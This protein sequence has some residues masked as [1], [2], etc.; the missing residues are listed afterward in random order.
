MFGVRCS[1]FT[2][3][4]WNNIFLEDDTCSQVQLAAGMSRVLTGVNDLWHR[5]SHPSVLLAVGIASACDGL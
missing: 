5:V 4:E 3:E 2:T 1:P